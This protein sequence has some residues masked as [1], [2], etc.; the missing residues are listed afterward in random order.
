[1]A[2]DFL[3]AVALVL[4]AWVWAQIAQA[5][6]ADAPR[7]R[8]PAQVLRERILPEL[9]LRVRLVRTACQSTLPAEALGA[10]RHRDKD[11]ASAVG[12]MAAE[13][14]PAAAPGKA[15]AAGGT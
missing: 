1:V 13:A 3:R 8:E 6:G 5:D 7:W 14:H 12:D 15:S 11:Q 2:D 4:L 9:D 10:D